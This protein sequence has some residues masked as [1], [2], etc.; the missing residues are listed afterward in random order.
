MKERIYISGAI[1]GTDDFMERFGKAQKE[2]ENQ[3]YSVI[4]P[5]LVNSNMPEDTT[6]AEYMKM[7]FTMLD[8]CQTI[9]LLNGWEKSTGANRER[10]YAINKGK[11]IIHQDGTEDEFILNLN[12][13]IKDIEEQYNGESEY[14]KE[15][16]IREN[17]SFVEFHYYCA[18]G[19][20]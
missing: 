11:N 18:M 4:N 3:G 20:R 14:I 13:K 2:L 8:M 10:E 1:T 5:A 7:A 15:L 6:Y 16:M 12:Q 9:Y 17:L 19:A